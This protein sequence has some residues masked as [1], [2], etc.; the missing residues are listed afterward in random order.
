MKSNFLVG[1]TVFLER[2]GDSP[3]RGWSV[4][5]TKKFDCI[6]I[7]FFLSNINIQINM[8]KTKSIIIKKSTKGG[9]SI[10]I[11]KRIVIKEKTIK[12]RITI[13]MIYYALVRLEHRRHHMTPDALRQE[14]RKL[15]GCTADLCQHC[16]DPTDHHCD[17]CEHVL[18][19]TVEC[20]C[21]CDESLHVCARCCKYY[22]Q[23]NADICEHNTRMWCIRHAQESDH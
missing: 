1:A 7:K 8:P 13:Y 11:K 6:L 19:W 5:P 9:K 22:N 12:K 18:H 2:S 20:E 17:D 15:H 4:T 3:T 10:I 21:G 16:L 23:M 14:Y